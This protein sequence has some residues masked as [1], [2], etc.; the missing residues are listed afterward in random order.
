MDFLNPSEGNGII[1]E[2]NLNHNKISNITC[3]THNLKPMLDPYIDYQNEKGKPWEV[4][5]PLLKKTISYAFYVQ[6]AVDYH[7]L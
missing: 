5:L 3:Q 2:L 6:I 1:W 4:D 7:L